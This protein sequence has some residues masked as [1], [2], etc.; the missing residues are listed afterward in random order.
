MLAALVLVAM[1][2]G[3]QALASDSPT[4]PPDRRALQSFDYLNVAGF[5]LL[6]EQR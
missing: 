5:E 1:L 4:V 2:L 3:R 6:G